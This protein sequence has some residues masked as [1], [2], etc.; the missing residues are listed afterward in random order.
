[1]AGPISHPGQPSIG[2]PSH[3]PGGIRAPA[4]PTPTPN[5]SRAFAVSEG[6]A[7]NQSPEAIN[8]QINQPTSLGLTGGP[9][10]SGIDQLGALGAQSGRGLA[11][12]FQA[13]GAVAPA[14]GGEIGGEFEDPL[15]KLLGR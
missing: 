9:D 10:I 3:R 8:A 12:R 5:I 14:F 6:G 11:S 15:R 4:A 2:L 13:E 1:M 7:V